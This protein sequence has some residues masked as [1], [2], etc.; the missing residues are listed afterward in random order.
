MN[1]LGEEDFTRREPHVVGDGEETDVT[2][3]VS[4]VRGAKLRLHK[5][6]SQEQGVADRGSARKGTVIFDWI[7]KIFFVKP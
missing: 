5:H 7:P 4:D 3:P 6:G 2:E 1:A